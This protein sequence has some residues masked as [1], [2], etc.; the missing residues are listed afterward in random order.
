MIGYVVT[1]VLKREMYLGCPGAGKTTKATERIINFITKELQNEIPPK[2]IFKSIIATS[3][4]NSA[5]DVIVEKIN[6]KLKGLVYNGI[7]L[8]EYQKKDF[9]F[10][11]T[12]HSICV[13]ELRNVNPELKIFDGDDLKEFIQL[14]PK[15]KSSFVEKDKSNISL[16]NLE[17]FNKD[18]FNK[19]I[20][21]LG[22]QKDYQIFKETYEDFKRS[23]NK[24]DFTDMVTM[25]LKYCQ[26]L[27]GIKFAVSDESNDLSPGLG[28]AF[29]HLTSGMKDGTILILADANQNVLE[30]SGSNLDYVT[31]Y[32]KRFP[33]TKVIPLEV[34]YRLNPNTIDQVEYL[35]DRIP[36][37]INSK[38][39]PYNNVRLPERKVFVQTFRSIKEELLEVINENQEK[40]NQIFFLLR[41]KCFFHLPIMDLMK[42][43]MAFTVYKKYGKEI[44]PLELGNKK[45]LNIFERAYLRT[46]PTNSPESIKIMTFTQSKGRE[47]DYAY[48]YRLIQKPVWNNFYDNPGPERRL[49]FTACS[50]AKQRNNVFLC[51]YDDSRSKNYCYDIK[52]FVK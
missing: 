35:K 32:T 17:A 41:N 38:I 49:L 23:K 5:A 7:S 47:C 12:I 21:E 20:K 2:E 37:R 15:Y 1:K 28:S 36:N 48:L 34:S 24:V 30:F 8:S 27:K 40:E 22:T 14:N 29:D 46:K 4:T 6:K 26:P 25:F 39:I 52:D 3:F 51:E 43:G 18:Y 50:R 33:E 44:Y 16:Y 31:N 19:K 13:K 9:P 10:I 45:N 11:G 42:L